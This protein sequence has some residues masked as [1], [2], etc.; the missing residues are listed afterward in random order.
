M[1]CFNNKQSYCLI[2]D[3]RY[4]EISK[5]AAIILANK[6]AVGMLY[7]TPFIPKNDGRTKRQGSKKRTWR[8]SDINMALPAIPILWKKFEATI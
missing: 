8:V 2:Y 6:S 5:Y 4:C 3:L 7:H 1:D